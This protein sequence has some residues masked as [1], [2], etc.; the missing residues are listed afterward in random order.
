M[1]TLNK[2]E[3][4]RDFVLESQD[5]FVLAEDVYH[6]F[7]S[8]IDYMLEDVLKKIVGS[9]N[10]HRN[11][12]LEFI[13]YGRLANY[14]SYE[15]KVDKDFF[16]RI[17]SY[18]Y[19]KTCTLLICVPGAVFDEKNMQ[20]V[21]VRKNLKTEF[22]NVQDSETW[23]IARLG[24]ETYESNYQNDFDLYQIFKDKNLLERLSG[25]FN[26]KFGKTIK[27]VVEIILS[28]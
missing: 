16:L 7:D 22:K 4:I 18:Y 11:L 26:D 8:I 28:T 20:H 25:D 21:A 17:E 24:F 23:Y 19:F 3:L 2:A 12:Q 15:L 14:Y 5:R 1:S 6:N 27:R 9:L 10:K 13:K